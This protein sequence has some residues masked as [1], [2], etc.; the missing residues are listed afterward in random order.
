MQEDAAL[1]LLQACTLEPLGVL[2]QA[3]NLT[4]LV[5]LT[6][7][8]E[9]TGHRGVYKPARGER[10]LHDFPPGSL[11]AREVAAY[12]VSRAG[13]FDLVP[14]TVLRDGP[15]GPGSVQWWVEQEPE[16][17]ADPSAGLVDVVTPEDLE[18]GWRAVVQAEDEHGAPVVV[19]HADDPALRTMATLDVL[20]NNA[21]RKAAHLTLDTQ[22]RLRGFDHGVSLHEEDKLRTVL[23][24]FAGEGMSEQDAGRVAA[25]AELLGGDGGTVEQL[26]TL[27]SAE[28]IS[29]LR[30]RTE[31]LLAAGILPMPP[32]GRYP[33]PWPLW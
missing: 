14:P 28:E 25:L 17:L 3:S 24:G 16:R 33:L 1:E 11:A 12:A 8:G 7:D 21:D 30:A 26:G 19:A 32:A 4:L 10:P 23:W 9:P 27:L 29:A 15:L 2:T 13:G 18:P 20:L 22:G 6:R 31:K 5:D